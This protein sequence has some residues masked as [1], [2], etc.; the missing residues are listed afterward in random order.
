MPKP[1]DGMELL[2]PPAVAQPESEA[3]SIGLRRL[4]EP[5]RRYRRTRTSPDSLDSAEAGK[6][7]RADGEFRCY[8]SLDLRGHCY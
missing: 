8:D 4:S 7:V 2:R 3:S 5:G 6:L 1:P